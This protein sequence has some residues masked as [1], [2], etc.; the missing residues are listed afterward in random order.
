MQDTHALEGKSLVQLREIAKAL[1][2]RNV[3][4]KKRDLIDK[5][6]GASQEAPASNES[7]P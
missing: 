7:Q 6:A 2:I 4:V 1:G 3:M 5:I